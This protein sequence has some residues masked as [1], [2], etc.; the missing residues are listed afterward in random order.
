MVKRLCEKDWRAAW[1]DAQSLKAA[2]ARRDALEIVREAPLAFVFRL[3]R[4]NRKLASRTLALPDKHSSSE[5][6]YFAGSRRKNVMSDVVRIDVLCWRRRLRIEQILICREVT[7]SQVPDAYFAVRE[8]VLAAAGHNGGGHVVGFNSYLSGGDPPLFRNE[9]LRDVPRLKEYNFRGI[10]VRCLWS[11]REFGLS[12]WRRRLKSTNKQ[13]L[14]RTM[15]ELEREV[16]SVNMPDELEI[17]V[18]NALKP[19]LLPLLSHKNPQ[20]QLSAHRVWNGLRPT[21]VNQ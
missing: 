13:E 5:T 3:A 4:K 14:E 9:V 17:K 7:V 2:W 10:P 19:L 12:A 20:I 18:F 8:S 1:C 15:D 6:Y 21:G 16:Y 11:L